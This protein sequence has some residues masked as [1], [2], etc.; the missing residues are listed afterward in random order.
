MRLVAIR[1]T[2][3]RMTKN[4]LERKRGEVEGGAM[5]FLFRFIFA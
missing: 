4:E 3:N 5:L 1:E 2:S